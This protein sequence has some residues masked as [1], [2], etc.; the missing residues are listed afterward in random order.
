[1][2]C[3]WALL[4]RPKTIQQGSGI[5][6]CVVGRWRREGCVD[7]CCEQNKLE[8]QCGKGQTRSDK[9]WLWRVL[10]LMKGSDTAL[11]LWWHPQL[12][13]ASKLS[14]PWR[15]VTH[16]CWG[17]VTSDLEQEA[18]GGSWSRTWR[19]CFCQWG[20]RPAHG[21]HFHNNPNILEQWLHLFNS[22]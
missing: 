3:F 5:I 21:Y 2:M 13:S 19:G 16:C 8:P 10:F 11:Y 17:G 14:N 9:V 22:H 4:N 18:V 20:W 7:M 1:M 6:R 12:H 15:A